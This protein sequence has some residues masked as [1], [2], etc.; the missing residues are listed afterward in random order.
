MVNYY[1][2]YESQCYVIIMKYVRVGYVLDQDP[3]IPIDDSFMSKRILKK[4]Q[5]SL[6]RNKCYVIDVSFTR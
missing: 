5:K 6:L 2:L 1:K 3:M 4:T